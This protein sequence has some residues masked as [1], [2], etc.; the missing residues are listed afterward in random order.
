MKT[1]TKPQVNVHIR[2][3]IRRDFPEVLAIEQSCFDWP[4]TEEDLVSH[5]R[6][7][8]I[9]AMSCE[10][11]ERVVGFMV[12][13]LQKHTLKILNFA[14]HESFR[15]RGVGR[16]MV[17]KL[18]SKLSEDRRS[19]ISVM[20]RESNLDGCLFF[21]AV[22]FVCVQTIRQPYEETEEDGYEFSFRYGWEQQA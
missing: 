22:G 9:I 15:H 20:V 12:Y 11:D 7:R 2:W 16:Q 14:V 18:A 6:Q 4:W 13:E 5:L 21:K 10:R 17:R 8:N 3:M 1:A 19:R